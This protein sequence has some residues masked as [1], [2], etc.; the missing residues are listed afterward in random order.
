M[1]EREKFIKQKEEELFI[2]CLG[3]KFSTQNLPRCSLSR[4]WRYF[5]TRKINFTWYHFWS[6][7]ILFLVLFSYYFLYIFG[8]FRNKYSEKKESV[9][10]PL[11]KDKL[12]FCFFS[13]SF[14]VFKYHKIS[15]F[16]LSFHVNFMSDF[17]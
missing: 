2:L 4:S 13:F 5:W 6:T 8:D 11:T 3:Q 15:S 10:T 16:L 9:Q 7:N 12:S 1:I 17:S 14:F